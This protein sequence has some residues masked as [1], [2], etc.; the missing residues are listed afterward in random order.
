MAKFKVEA[1]IPDGSDIS[2]LYPNKLSLD[3]VNKS[4]ATLSDGT[5]SVVLKGENLVV[6]NDVLVA[7]TLKS[8]EFVNGLTGTEY[9]SITGLDLRAKPLGFQDDMQIGT[10]LQ[11]LLMQ[12]D[13][14]LGSYEGDLLFGGGGKDRM[15]GRGGSDL[16]YGLF[17]DDRLT[18]GAGSDFFHVGDYGHDIITDFDSVGDG[19][20]Q[21]Y[22]AVD[23]LPLSIK[24]KG[25]DTLIDFGDGVRVTLLNVNA[26]TV[27]D[28]DFI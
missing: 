10:V 22:M 9:A 7:G 2:S 11:R 12:D 15:I 5:G 18:G 20:N 26:D 13:L 4:T 27:T 16:I 6:R 25:L 21:D 17:D 19:E 28:A 14:V 3:L 8:V 1:T 24:P 23:T